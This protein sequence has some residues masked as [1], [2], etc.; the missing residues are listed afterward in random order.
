MSTRLHE[1]LSFFNP[2]LPLE[3]YT[4]LL[5]ELKGRYG[6]HLHC[7]SPTEVYGMAKTFKMGYGEVLEEETLVVGEARGG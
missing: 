7:F 1:L 2:D 3:W 4:R 5:S 6:I